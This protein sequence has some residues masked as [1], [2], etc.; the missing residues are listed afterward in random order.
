LVFRSLTSRP[1]PIHGFQGTLFPA[2]PGHYPQV[3]LLDTG[4]ALSA[5]EDRCVA[6]VPKGQSRIAQRFNAGLDAKMSRVPKGRL[7]TNPTPHHSA[8]P[9]SGLVCHAES[10]PA[11]KRRTL[12]FGHP[13]PVSRSERTMVAVGLLSSPQDG[14]HR[15]A[16]SLSPWKGE[17]VRERGGL[18]ERKQCWVNVFKAFPSPHSFVAGRGRRGGRSLF[19]FSVVYPAAWSVR[20]ALAGKHSKSPA[21]RRSCGLL[22][23]LRFTPHNE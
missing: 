2:A 3:V 6:A 15:E 5:R 1:G 13:L 8:V 12:E 23:I 16:S 10:C 9:A 20:R 17:R 14:L 19:A 21:C 22:C 18:E 4:S 7:R 11:L